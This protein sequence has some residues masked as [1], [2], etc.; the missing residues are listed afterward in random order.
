MVPASHKMFWGKSVQIRGKVS[1]QN[2]TQI[3]TSQLL[4][5]YCETEVLPSPFQ[6]LLNTAS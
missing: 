4:Y 1:V 3:A 6:S 5:K 2:L